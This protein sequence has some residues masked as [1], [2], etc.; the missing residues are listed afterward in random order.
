M[1]LIDSVDKRC[2][3]FHSFFY[4]YFIYYKIVVWLFSKIG[5]HRKIIYVEHPDDLPIAVKNATV[6]LNL[7]TSAI[8][9]PP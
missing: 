8:Q 3:N 6:R 4:F 9:G 1:K 5:K 7:L 2:A